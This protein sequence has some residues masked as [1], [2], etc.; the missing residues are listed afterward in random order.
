MTNAIIDPQTADAIKSL[1]ATWQHYAL[2]AFVALFT[3]G[4]IATALAANAGLAG[5][6]KSVFMGS[7]H[8]SQSPP[9]TTV[10]PTIAAATVAPPTAAVVAKVGLLAFCIIALSAFTACKQTLAPGGDYNPVTSVVGGV[11]NTNHE[12]VLFQSDN[13]FWT[14]YNAVDAALTIERNNRQLLWN[15]NPKIKAT[16]DLI[17]PDCA[18]AVRSYLVARSAYMA[19]PTPANASTLTTWVSKI[20]QILSIVSPVVSQL[21]SVTSK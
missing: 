6:I 14:A 5:A 1:P 13:A 16:L 21:P 18:T 19:F 3:L 8:V 4:R 7:A 20:Q 15:F 2:L 9:D 12:M 10:A 17:R 11:T